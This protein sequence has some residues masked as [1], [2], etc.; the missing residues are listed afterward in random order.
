MMTVVHPILKKANRFEITVIMVMR[1]KVSIIIMYV[2]IKKILQLVLF[3]IIKLLV[4]KGW[5]IIGVL[6]CQENNILKR[7]L[8]VND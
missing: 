4:I 5:P 7:V 3:K 6:L 2:F 8:Y 1:L